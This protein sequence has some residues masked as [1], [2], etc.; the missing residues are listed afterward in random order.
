MQAMTKAVEPE[1]ISGRMTSD[2]L[3]SNH[4][5]Y[6]YNAHGT[7]YLTY[8]VVTGMQRSLASWDS[9]TCTTQPKSRLAAILNAMPIGSR[10]TNLRLRYGFRNEIIRSNHQWLKVTDNDWVVQD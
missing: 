8:Q 5:R 10:V 7:D 1:G 2:Q 6:T 3:I 4:A 9:N